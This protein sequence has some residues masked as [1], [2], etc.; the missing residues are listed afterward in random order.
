M[1]PQQMLGLKSWMGSLVWHQRDGTGQYYRRNRY[2]EPTTNR[3]TQEDPIGLAG[4]INLYGYAS[5]HPVNYH[6]PFGLDRIYQNRYGREV[7][8][9]EQEGADEYYLRYR[10]K[11]YRLERALVEG[12]A[13]YEVHL[14]G[15][16]QT[17]MRL[18]GAAPRHGRV[19]AGFRSLPGESP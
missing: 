15:A 12:D 8:R 17:A 7:H 18:A 14:S 11:D 13:P 19:I 4:G 6:D 9:V 3:F 2:Y 1:R 10:G 5:G 16:D